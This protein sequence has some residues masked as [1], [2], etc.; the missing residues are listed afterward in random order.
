[1]FEISETFLPILLWRHQRTQR[2]I[3]CFQCMRCEPQLVQLW[4]R[5]LSRLNIELT[6]NTRHTCAMI[7]LNLGTHLKPVLHLYLNLVAAFP[8]WGSVGAWHCE[9]A[10]AVTSISSFPC[11]CF[12]ACFRRLVH[13]LSAPSWQFNSWQRDW[14]NFYAMKTW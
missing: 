1:M 10:N 11:W 3:R 5:S 4:Q 2:G 8:L 9:W 7:H 6:K 14:P 12:S 13:F